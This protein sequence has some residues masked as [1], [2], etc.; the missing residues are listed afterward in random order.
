M[1]ATAEQLM[2]SRY[3][4]YFF[5]LVNYL[6]ATTHP[7]EKTPRMAEE[8]QEIADATSWRFLEI[9]AT[10][11]GG[12]EDKSGKVEFLATYYVNNVE[13]QHHEVSRFRR[14]Q[15][16]WRYVDNRG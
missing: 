11:K 1:P 10:S 5:R 12:K 15:G 9:L 4:A 3:S 6:V 8:I 14:Y 13:H 7:D 2:R 16:Q